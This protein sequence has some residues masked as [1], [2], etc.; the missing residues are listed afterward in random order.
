MVDLPVRVRL[1]LWYVGLLAGALALFAA[2]VYVLM[3]RSLQS[4]LD[5]SL[6]QRMDQIVPTLDVV[7]GQLR[8]GTAGEQPETPYVP[9]ALLSVR[10]VPKTSGIPVELTRWLRHAAPVLPHVPAVETVGGFRLGIEPV[11]NNNKTIGYILV[12]QSTAALDQSRRSL[13]FLLL[14]LGPGLLLFAGIGGMF[15]ARRALRPVTEITA[16]AAG[17]TAS[18]LHRRVPV[19]RTRD[20]LSVLAGTF[21]AMIRRLESAV[22]RERRFTGDASHELRA[23]LSVILAESSLALEGSLEPNEGREA[24]ITIHEQASGMSEMIAALLL[25]ARLENLDDHREVVSVA[26]VVERAVRQSVPVATAQNV[27]LEGAIDPTFQIHGHRTL[28]V[29][30]VRNVLDNAVKAST[31]GGTVRYG[32]CLVGSRIAVTVEDHGA[33]IPDEHLEHIFEPF[34]QVEQARTPGDSHGLGL[35]ICTRVVRAH[36][37]SVTA[38]SRVGVGTTLTLTLPVATEDSRSDSD[39]GMSRSD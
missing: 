14:S 1:T 10:G 33:G 31:D 2:T 26:D 13:L 39:R 4:N 21:N 20:E 7:N 34:F 16:A 9:D 19:G 8:A 27:V 30:A 22:E 23:P 25:L 35:A 24:L 12:W 18:D 38:Q 37:G 3:S 28:L 15:V 17:I 36:G 11:E 5:T 32:A 6:R 29:R